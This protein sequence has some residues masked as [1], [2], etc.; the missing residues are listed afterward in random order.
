MPGIGC[1]LRI[2]LGSLKLQIDTIYLEAF[3]DLEQEGYYSEK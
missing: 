2:Y 3:R 1:P